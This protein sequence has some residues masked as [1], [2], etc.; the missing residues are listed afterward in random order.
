MRASLLARVNAACLR[1]FS[2]PVAYTPAGGE[3]VTLSGIFEAPHQAAEIGLRL[4]VSDTAPTLLVRLSDFT[5]DGPRQGD[6][7]DV[8]GILYEVTD[9][10]PDG[11]GMA[12]LILVQ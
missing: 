5:L 1:T 11:A 8:A 6:H 12:K 7:V 10:Q 9:V 3:S 4:P 2:Q